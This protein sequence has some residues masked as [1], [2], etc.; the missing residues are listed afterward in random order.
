MVFTA[1]FYD[2]LIQEKKTT[3]TSVTD[4]KS[5]ASGSNNKIGD[6]LKELEEMENNN[7]S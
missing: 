2:N 1:N 7:D 6:L 5:E 3:K 4:D